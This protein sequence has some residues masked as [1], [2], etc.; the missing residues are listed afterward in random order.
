[1]VQEK[2]LALAAKK[3]AECQ[4][5]IASLGQQLKSL[6]TVDEILLDSEKPLDQL[7]D[8]GIQSFKKGLEAW[9]L[10]SNDLKLPRTDPDMPKA[11]SK[12]SYH[13]KNASERKPS[14]SNIR[15]T[16]RL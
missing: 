16:H 9:K 13:S 2:E 12:R 5:T 10:G 4:K 15:P 11:T 6:A 8:E 14:L 7:T 1:M 3:F